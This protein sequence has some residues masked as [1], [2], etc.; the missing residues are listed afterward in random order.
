MGK[1][2][3]AQAAEPPGAQARVRPRHRR[4]PHVQAVTRAGGPGKG[5]GSGA[6]PLPLG[7]LPFCFPIGRLEL[8]SP[9]PWVEVRAQQE[10]GGWE[11]GERCRD[12][13]VP[14][15]GERSGQGDGELLSPWEVGPRVTLQHCPGP[16]PPVPGLRRSGCPRRPARQPGQGALGLALLREVHA[17]CL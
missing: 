3:K 12:G 13:T 7:L 8:L 14:H 2:G 9:H 11:P 1:H 4:S 15:P 16:S 17:S 10:R 6:V 5:L